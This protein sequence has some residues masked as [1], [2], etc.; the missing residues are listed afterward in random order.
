MILGRTH[1]GVAALGAVLGIMAAALRADA[2]GD[3]DWDAIYVVGQGLDLS[4]KPV[5]D[6][7][8]VKA[9]GD[10][11]AALDELPGVETQGEGLGKAWTSLSIRG[12][13]FRDT[14]ILLD[15]V[16]VPESFN[17]G[18]LPTENLGS[19][20]VLEGPQALALGSGALGG[21]V[22]L[23]TSTADQKDFH[24]AFS[25]GDYNTLQYRASAPTFN[26]GPLRATFSG[27]YYRTDGYLPPVTGLNGQTFAFTDQEHWD[28][29]SVMRA[30]WG[31]DQFSM[32]SS[33]F[34]H[35]GSAPD[36]DNVIAA[37]T[38]Q[39]D[40]DGRQDS[41]GLRSQAVDQHALGNWTLKTTA[42][43]S[44]SE[45]FRQNPIG[46]DPTSGVYAPYRSGYDNGGAS[47]GL[48]GGLGASLPKL[49]LG[50]A[51]D[52]EGL[53]SGL[54]GF[55]ERWTG[56]FSAAGT[57]QIAAA[58]R[59]EL[60]NR[61]EE[62][63]DAELD[64]SPTGTLYWSPSGDFSLH[65]GCGS[66]YQRPTF[67]QLYLPYTAFA[68][69]PP[70]FQGSPFISVWAGDKGNPRLLT[71]RST[72]AEFG[73]DWLSGP[74]L[75]QASCFEN[76]YD[77]LINPAV[78]PKD[79]FWTYVNVDHASFTGMEA[80]VKLLVAGMLVPSLSGTW[81]QAVDGAGQPVPGRMKEKFTA[82]L[83][84]KP[85]KSWRLGLK[86]RY[87]QRNPVAGWYL[88]DLGL[89]PPTNDYWDY[90]ADAAWTVS[91]HLEG[92]LTAENLADTQY[93]TFQGIPS[94]GRHFSAG[95]QGSF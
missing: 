49:S 24:L 47:L 74:L 40:L 81:V 64:D 72:N 68:S 62:W 58:W 8:T 70:Q 53:D 51:A 34:R 86:A 13:S 77:Q 45:V 54:Y 35:H 4:V 41:W 67:D 76:Y 56:T 63:V 90:S 28:L 65:L 59:L 71:E 69:L 14:A 17:L 15:G 85:E 27:S 48:S 36:S 89:P 83:D 78:D 3:P 37:G 73:G 80:A 6:L 26:L 94:P 92:F 32:I 19:V 39:Y 22:S 42:Y 11:G 2:A 57:W 10:L 16:P 33:Y 30:Q 44:V 82:S 5:A 84:L 12:Q 79:N 9:G 88:T 21:A 23:D 93:A 60:A 55:H 75:V 20:E 18:T 29:D 38:D 31:S 46:A 66:G 25:E 50:L 95:L 61:L 7:A 52:Q 1:W 87:V 43:G 91:E